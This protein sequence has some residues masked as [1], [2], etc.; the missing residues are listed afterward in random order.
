MHTHDDI[1]NAQHT[2]PLENTNQG[3]IHKKLNLFFIVGAISLVVLLVPISL[4]TFQKLTLL[5]ASQA[6]TSV[7]ESVRVHLTES[8]VNGTIHKRENFFNR[9]REE[10]SLRDIEVKRSQKVIEQFGK[11]NLSEQNPDELEARVLATGK[12]IF[13]RL[14]TPKG[15]EIIRGVIPYAAVSPT[16]E[17]HPNC[18]GCHNVKVG[19]VLGAISITMHIDKIV[20][21][22]NQTIAIIIC[23]VGGLMLTMLVFAHNFLANPLSQIAK[24]ITESVR[25]A[26]KGD[27]R[28]N[29]S[30]YSHDELGHIA[31]QL[32][33]LFMFLNLGF[34]HIGR[35]ILLLTHQ[36]PTIDRSNNLLTDT[37]EKVNALVRISDFKQAISE[38]ETKRDVYI[39]FANTLRTEFGI[40]ECSIYELSE[41]KKQLK[42]IF[43]SGNKLVQDGNE[44]SQL[45]HAN[46]ID[47]Y[48]ESE[49]KTEQCCGNIACWCNPD[50]LENSQKC[51]LVRTGHSIDGLSDVTICTS[52]QPTCKLDDN[53]KHIPCNKSC[54]DRHYLCLPIFRSTGLVAVVQILVPKD[55]IE[56]LQK[57]RSLIEIYLSEMS[58]VIESKHLLE[59]LKNATLHD[60]LTGLKNRRFLEEYLEV[61]NSNLV[62]NK[63]KMTILAM[64]VDHFKSVNDTY[65]H[66]AGDLV[67]KHVADTLKQTVRKTDF[68]IRTGG[69]EFLVL[70][71]NAPI[72][73]GL[74]VAEKI[75]T[76]MEK[77]SIRVN[78]ST[79][80]QKTISIGVVEYPKEFTEKSNFWLAVKHA[81]IALYQAKKTG[82]NKV[83]VY[84][85][86]NPD[87][88]EAERETQKG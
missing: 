75:R 36:N 20:A 7:G 86:D 3:S 81:D 83:V 70:L 49:I 40:T 87:N 35:Q 53:D 67:L 28:T 10:Q 6:I 63:N 47:T 79:T 71:V 5:T 15:E 80:L 21:K 69:E 85:A 57:K 33:H 30:G 31:K 14:T 62:R 51:R 13:Q 4:Y 44:L 73:C 24:E 25:S 78:S 27:F 42:P 39:R 37:L 64:D 1:Q 59:N 12:P 34:T 55:R 61:L 54:W 8:M 76:T 9:I 68:V 56:E 50:I 16:K 23:A 66:D 41:D 82:R 72:N 88:E 48:P 65:G 77:S 32:N 38:D 18:I 2:L 26:L 74:V 45:L 60:T 11:G 58:P 46:N 22:S 52:Y 29:I 43:I 17:I 84:S 19:D